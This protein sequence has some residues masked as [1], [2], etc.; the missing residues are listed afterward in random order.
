MVAAPERIVMLPDREQILQLS[1]AE[2]VARV[3]G[4]VHAEWVD[5]EAIVFMSPKERH[6]ALVFFLS[7]LVGNFVLWLDR[8]IV[9]T[10][11]YEMRILPDGPAREPDILFVAREHLERITDDGLVGPADL[12]IEVVSEESFKRDR[13]TKFYEYEAGGVPEYWFLD[14][15]PHRER[16]EFYRL[17]AAGRYVP[18]LPDAHGRYHSVALPSFWLDPKWLWQSPHPNPLLL[19]AEIAP[20]AIRLSR[21]PE[22]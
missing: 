6:Q 20:Q 13:D 11:P 3:D 12:V 4:G 22:Q 17:D 14:P 8:G 21:P 15:R 7:L 16:A 9:R 10:A 2:F 19:L 1:Y 18:I 5:G